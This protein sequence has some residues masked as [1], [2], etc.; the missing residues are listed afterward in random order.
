[1]KNFCR[2]LIGFII[3]IFV[4]ACMEELHNDTIRKVDLSFTAFTSSETKTALIEGNKIIWLPGDEIAVSGTE[5]P[6]MVSIS[7]PSEYAEFTGS[8][9][10][11]STYLAV[12]PYTLFRLWTE[13]GMQVEI[14]SVQQAVNGSFADDLNLSVAKTTRQEMSLRFKNVSGYV[15][16]TLPE[17]YDHLIK[18]VSIM[19]DAGEPLA[20]VIEVDYSG[21]NI[22]L[23]PTDR[24]S[25]SVTLA[26]STELEAGTY[27]MSM[28][29]G[30]YSEG[31]SI[32][33]KNLRN[34]EAVVH[35]S[36]ELTMRMGQIRN[37]GV[38]SNLSFNNV[39][40]VPD[41]EIWYTSTDNKIVKPY[42]ATF[43]AE[44]ISNTYEGGIGILRFDGKVTKVGERAFYNK[45]QITSV[46]LPE[47]IKEIDKQAFLSCEAITDV[48]FPVALNKIGDEAFCYC[49]SMSEVYIPDNVS[50]IGRFA[51]YGCSSMEKVIIAQGVG[52][53][54]QQAFDSCPGILYVNC[55]IPDL[56]F[57]NSSFHK[58]H[59][60]E[61]V[62]SIGV[63]AF[64][65]NI[66]LTEINIPDNV[67]VVEA[68]SFFNCSSL[69]KVTIGK[70]VCTI[71]SYSFSSCNQLNEIV[72]RPLIPPQGHTDFLGDIGSN[73]TIY[74]PGGLKASYCAMPFWK[75]YA[76]IIVED[77]SF[78][79]AVDNVY[80]STDF[81]SD[82][83]VF[84]LQ[85]ATVGNGIDVVIM[86]DGYSDRMIA[87]G[88]YDRIIKQA[89]DAFFSVEPYTTYKDF[90][91]VYGIRTV[92]RNELIGNGYET[93]LSTVLGE[94]TQM[95][96]DNETIFSYALNVIN[97]DRMDETLIVVPVNSQSHS[98]TCFIYHPDITQNDYGSGSAI[99]FFAT[100]I[101][102]M[103]FETT[104]H[105]ECGHGF[106]K[107]AD[108]Y[109]YE[110][111]GAIP[112]D[113]ILNRNYG[114]LSF[115]WWK[116]A[117]FTN[118]PNKVKWAHFLNDERYAYD[119]LGVFEGAFTYMTGVWRPTE[120]SIMHNNVGGF[121]APSREA[122]WYRINKLAYGADWV[123]EYEDF[124]EYDSK[125][126]NTS[127]LLSLSAVEDNFSER[128]SEPT[129]PPV[130]S[131]KSW[132]TILGK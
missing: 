16:F 1:M 105:H 37:I 40:T 66:S 24:V 126:R 86:G 89:Y 107:L 60:G 112:K 70:K 92:S 74:V 49:K 18:S 50:Y 30:T 109:F 82:G 127:H 83:E 122:V 95:S 17:S 91:N 43:D 61:N 41:N 10:E 36:G 63:Y 114:S 125:N 25:S 67:S 44:L 14:P 27:Y 96:G 15:K 21:D 81:S 104:L 130:V 119:G 115:G 34:E 12:Y 131:E 111:M 28:I 79:T 58:V 106:A 94:G 77:E 4:S 65:G 46:I 13:S 35:I 33:F 7:D 98:G 123:Y 102:D 42:N 6:F 19:T 93:A 71:G 51:F 56:S 73:K 76:S 52:F 84:V 9:Y 69:E 48:N 124:V 54:E 62:T 118:D 57:R 113:E 75:D 68:Y 26:S 59:I 22:I 87:D 31:L 53:I 20:G 38:I 45:D 39:N 72:L 132:R 80:E 29:P 8:A 2:Y 116:N 23:S 32:T 120:T 88:T 55:D 97:E 121:N 64:G 3:L 78:G 90:F 108:E 5:D 11:L 101:D 99:A 110:Y 128:V 117:D 129:A 100:G 85:T 47:S 103:E